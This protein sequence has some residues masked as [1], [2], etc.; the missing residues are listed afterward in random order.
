VIKR[1]LAALLLATAA[2]AQQL[3][4]VTLPGEGAL[5]RAELADVIARAEAH[6]L[7][8]GIAVKAIKVLPLRADPCESQRER[9]RFPSQFACY[10]RIGLDLK[11]FRYGPTLLVSAPMRGGGERWLGGVARRDCMR[12]ISRRVAWAAATGRKVTGEDRKIMAGILAA[13][14]VAHTLGAAH[15]DGRPNIMHSEALVFV[16]AGQDIAFVSR[17]ADEMR[18]CQVAGGLRR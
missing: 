18:S 2:E 7:A 11:R 1:L 17:S 15:Y 4:V 8:R 12:H 3:R 16:K 5:D 13:H 9:D 6:F 10:E 14:E